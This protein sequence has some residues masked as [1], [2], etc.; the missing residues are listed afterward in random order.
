M[1]RAPH[2]RLSK[3]ESPSRMRP[4]NRGRVFG[5]QVMNKPGV[6]V[7]ERSG[8]WATAIRR[9]L[10]AEI[11]LRQTRGL[12]ECAA[13]LS[14]APQSLLALE[15]TPGNL[16]GVLGLL[17]GLGRKFRRPNRA[18]AG[19]GPARVTISLSGRGRSPLIRGLRPARALAGLGRTAAAP[20]RARLREPAQWPTASGCR[21]GRRR[22]SRAS[23]AARRPTASAIAAT[24][25]TPGS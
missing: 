18:D 12:A 8:A 23:G 15:L 19:F 10:P 9:Y 11:R 7:C 25:A 13:E 6:I 20:G 3:W 4:E 21:A 1:A 17:S 14:A 2:N 16:A 5:K 22:R 24:T